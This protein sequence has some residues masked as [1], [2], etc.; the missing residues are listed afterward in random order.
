M[1]VAADSGRTL[2]VI[3]TTPSSSERT[4]IGDREV[5]VRVYAERGKGSAQVSQKLREGPVDL[6]SRSKSGRCVRSA[7][8]MRVL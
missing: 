8:I 4:G 1:D 5:L 3:A 2:A 7:G 6:T